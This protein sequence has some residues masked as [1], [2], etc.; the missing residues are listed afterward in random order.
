MNLLANHRTSFCKKAVLKDTK[1]L[2]QETIC[3][4][5]ASGS[6][7]KF[8]C[9]SLAHIRILYNILHLCIFSSFFVIL[10]SYF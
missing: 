7:L 8:A 3:L 4:L 10:T 2:A 6:L 1:L 5:Q 9:L